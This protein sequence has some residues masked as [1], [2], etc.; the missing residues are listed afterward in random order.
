VSFDGHHV[1]LRGHMPWMYMGTDTYAHRLPSR[2]RNR[3]RERDRERE[4]EKKRARDGRKR[5]LQLPSSDQLCIQMEPEQRATARFT[6]HVSSRSAELRDSSASELFQ[7][8]K[9]HSRSRYRTAHRLVNATVRDAVGMHYSLTSFIAG[10][11]AARITGG[12]TASSI[13]P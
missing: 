11:S 3:E 10:V 2:T 4:R 12:T 7:G 13:T 9:T 1:R 5:I 8:T 6:F